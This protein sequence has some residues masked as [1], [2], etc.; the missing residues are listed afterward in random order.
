M[1]Y[2]IQVSGILTVYDSTP[3]LV[4]GDSGSGLGRLSSPRGVDVHHLTGIIYVADLYSHR[5]CEFNSS[6]HAISCMSGYSGPGSVTDFN[7]PRDISV[8]TNGRMV[9]CDEH[10]VIVTCSN[11]TL[12]HVWG[13]LTRGQGL[14]QFYY[15]QAV[16]SDGDLIY[17]ADFGNHRIQ[18]LNVANTG[19][20]EVIEVIADNPSVSYKPWGIA[21]DR[22]SGYIFV[23][24][25]KRS[26]DGLYSIHI[27][28]TYNM[29]GHYVC[30][31]TASDL[32]VDR[33]GLIRIALYRGRV[34][35]SDVYN[36]CIHILSYNGSYIQR[37]GRHGTCPGCF[38]YPWGVAVHSV[39]GHLIVSDYTNNNVQIFRP[40]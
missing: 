33:T 5:V 9:I 18:V 28:I 14:G 37:L 20:I 27:I 29:T 38:Q 23:T 3:S 36:T 40:L 25:S 16:A 15:P 11:M 12:I 39:T 22:A 24:S 21:V 6:G 1:F 4:F 31:V 35:V 10:R 7:L 19:D 26:D 13:S 30:H 8:M 17:V 32:G 34:Y 2:F